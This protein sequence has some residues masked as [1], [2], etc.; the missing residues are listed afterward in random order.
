ML[1]MMDKIKNR[2]VNSETKKWMI[3]FSFFAA[4]VM[5]Y[6]IRIS[7]F[8]DGDW[9]FL[10]FEGRRIARGGIQY[11]NG[12]SP[13]KGLYIVVQQWL[14][15]L[16]FYKVHEMTGWNGIFV[17]A[18]L[19][20]VLFTWL[21]VRLAEVHG[22]SG[23]SSLGVALITGMA[24]TMFVAA[25]KPQ[26][27]TECLVMAEMICLEKY[28][29]TEQKK[30]LVFSVMTVIAEANFHVSTWLVHL[31]FAVPYM[32]P[33]DRLKIR[34]GRRD[35]RYAA[36]PVCLAG[37]AMFS[38]SMMAPYGID[39]S[40]YTFTAY[41]TGMAKMGISELESPALSSK[42]CI[43]A[44][45]FAACVFRQVRSEHAESF[46]TFLGSFAMFA[47]SMRN[48][49]FLLISAVP[50][51]AGFVHE[52][53]LDR[54]SRLKK[55]KLHSLERVF[56]VPLLCG[57]VC[58]CVFSASVHISQTNSII[59]P[60][61][62]L[63]YLK[64]YEKNRHARIMTTFDTGSYMENA[65]YIISIDGR[66]EVWGKMMNRKVNMT[67]EYLKLNNDPSYSFFLKLRRKYRFQY[68]MANRG[69]PLQAMCEMDRTIHVVAEDRMC[70]LYKVF[71][72]EPGPRYM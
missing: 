40:L 48:I 67:K 41:A 38:A 59:Y 10:L 50:A 15:A 39:G 52:M 57:A 36:V 70:T 54:L 32:I 34:I 1:L 56:Y 46:L 14:Y 31:L 19:E 43:M 63:K 12:A 69:T 45:I 16:I 25:E 21:A 35:R 20:M 68:I 58:L 62:A 28:A 2:Y 22:H 71:S 3:V 8:H 9:S 44:L 66:S 37:I 33:Y 60:K 11:T 55:L 23:T 24:Y 61:Y 17:M 51:L 42:I 47:V 13:V 29:Q 30:Y 18:S 4:A 72:N 65:G 5:A 49:Q 27:I 26:I 53:P 7:M 6:Y 64:R